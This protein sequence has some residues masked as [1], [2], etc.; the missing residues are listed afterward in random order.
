MF[1]IIHKKLYVSVVNLSAN[2]KATLLQQFKSGFKRIIN[3]NRYQ[4]NLTIQQQNPN[5]D[6]IIDPS[7]QGVN[8]LFVLSFVLK[9]YNVM[10]DG[11]NFFYYP[12]KRDMRTYYNI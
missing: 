2:D 7:F 6:K 12:N 5:L 9:S 4:S 8:R 1:A 11:Q 10:M 3:W